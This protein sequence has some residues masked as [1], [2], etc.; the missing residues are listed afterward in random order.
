MSNPTIAVLYQANDM[1]IELAGLKNGLDDTYYNAAT[2]QVT[3]RDAAGAEVAGGPAWP[4]ALTYVAGSNG[5]YRAVL[6][7][8]ITLVPDAR[9]SA[10]VTADAG[11]GLKARWELP[12]VCRVR[13]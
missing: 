5:V 11:N 4:Q 9:Y 6:D 1:L 3:L 10:I 13:K 12:C 8:S 2:V 7:D